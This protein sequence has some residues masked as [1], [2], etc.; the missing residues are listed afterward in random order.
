MIGAQVGLTRKI[1]ALRQPID[2]PP[3]L[4]MLSAAPST[5]S[6]LPGI[7]HLYD[8]RAGGLHIAPTCAEGHV[9]AMEILERTGWMNSARD[10]VAAQE[11]RGV[12]DRVLHRQLRDH[13]PTPPQPASVPAPPPPP[14][15]EPDPAANT[16]GIEDTLPAPAGM[17]LTE[18]RDLHLKNLSRGPKRATPATRDRGY[19]LNLLIETIGDLPINGVTSDHASAFADLL[20]S[21]PARRHHFPQLVEL[22][23]PAV[24]ARAKR[25]K[26]QPI[27]LG[28]QHKHLMHVNALMNWAIKL[29]QIAENPFRYVDTA[30]YMRD[31][32]GR[33]RKKKDIFHSAD[34]A[35][36]FDPA[37]MASYK[38]PHK[39]W[40]PLIGHYT[41]MRVN[42]IAQL[43]LD[44][45]RTDTYLDETGQERRVMTFDIT[46]DREG[47]SV[48]TDYAVRRIP[49]PQK[50]LDLGFDRYLEDVR[51]SGASHLF[52][53]LPWNEG[54]PGR[55]V[56]QWFN[57]VILRKSCGI[58]DRRKSLHSLRHTMTTLMDRHHV[59]DS[60]IC[61]INGHSTGDT[62]DKRNYVADGTVLECQRVI[63]TLPFPDIPLAPYVSER[64]EGYLKHAKAEAEREERARVK[65]VKFRRRMGRP[66]VRE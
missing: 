48:K 46:G 65:Q 32:N 11:T 7:P 57:D 34:L 51:A 52:P 63:D 40:V 24:V 29:E 30:R 33:R 17:R 5:G 55:T 1:L 44:D 45:V 43:H 59:P 9:L 54:G 21:W 8:L 53:G 39:F 27:A 31:A 61:A 26:I 28:T 49:V 42:E 38:D 60:L 64:F 37:R 12:L 25:E 15:E 3:G 6:P 19:A 2:F 13:A 58:T 35:A 56:S 47:Q 62:I 41:G 4:F 50:L 10:Q 16:V 20:A 22:S 36:I 14:P 66:P 18:L 23:A